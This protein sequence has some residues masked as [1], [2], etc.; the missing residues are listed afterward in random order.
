MMD[1]QLI[2]RKNRLLGEVP[3]SAARPT[4]TL[5]YQIISN[6]YEDKPGVMIG[7]RFTI[8]HALTVIAYSLICLRAWISRF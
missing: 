7:R 8:H 3:I 5:F 6:D 4:S 2:Y 1:N